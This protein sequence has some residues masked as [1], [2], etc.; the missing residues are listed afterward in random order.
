MERILNKIEKGSEKSL[1]F[2]EKRIMR[3]I[4]TL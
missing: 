4:K 1:P 2:Q 3:G